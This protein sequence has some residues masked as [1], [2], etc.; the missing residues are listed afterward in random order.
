MICFSL[1]LSGYTP[2]LSEDSAGTEI[3]TIE[4]HCLLTCSSW[5]AQSALLH[6]PGPPAQG[7]TTYSELSPCRSLQKLPSEICA[8]FM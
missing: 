2:S 4:E 8:Y 6:N 3:G 1:Q 5:L 7:S